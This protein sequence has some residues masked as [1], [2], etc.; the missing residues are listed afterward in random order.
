M[1]KKQKI[2][3]FLWV[4]SY[5]WRY[6]VRFIFGLLTGFFTAISIFFVLLQM[7]AVFEPLQ[8]EKVSARN[9]TVVRENK[10]LDLSINY[11]ND[12]KDGLNPNDK[13]LSVKTPSLEDLDKKKLLGK[14]PASV[15]NWL[16]NNWNISLE[17]E[18]QV[19]KV[20]MLIT[21]FFL[22]LAVLFK[23]LFSYI[24]SYLL[25]WLSL[26]FADD[27]RKEMIA[28]ILKKPMSFYH[29]NSVGEL[30]SRS[31]NDVNNMSR[32]IPHLL[33]AFTRTPIEFFAIFSFLVYK[34]LTSSNIDQAILF[35]LLI[36]PFTLIPAFFL[37]RYIKKYISRSLK[38]VASLTSTKQELFSCIKLI[39][40]SSMEEKEAKNFA[41]ESL[42]FFRDKKK[43]AR[44]SLAM[45]PF[46]ELFA[47]MIMAIFL[48]YC[49]AQDVSISSVLVICLSIQFAYEP[50]KKIS[51]LHAQI[52]TLRESSKRV[53]E[54]LE[55]TP[56]KTRK[57]QQSHLEKKSFDSEIEFKDVSFQY[58]KEE[59]GVLKN[60]NLKIKKGQFI[61]FVG[62]VGSGKTTMINLLARFYHCTKG[63]ILIDGIKIDDISLE[64]YYSNFSFVTQVNI[65]FNQSLRGNLTY[66]I[67]DFDEK[68][69]SEISKICGV[70][71]IA[72]HKNN[73]YD[74]VVGASGQL[75]SGGQRQRVS[76][77]RA[78]LK[79]A[80]ILVLDEATS[81]L[82]NI[83]EKRLQ[84]AIDLLSKEKTIIAVAHRLTTVRNADIIYVMDKGEIVEQGTH[85]QLVAQ[86]GLYQSMWHQ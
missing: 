41:Q 7:E 71:R 50:I 45:R 20:L 81:S 3:T 83:T 34:S 72:S 59:E 32:T 57:S 9:L 70:N 31:N 19:S 82:D 25:E 2:S 15:R 51:Q 58:H 85:S 65:L 5:L 30:I 11:P 77:A 43:I 69:L 67:D 48:Y 17:T 53:R 84:S 16:E 78:L 36:A 40:T 47:I 76:I 52:L 4:S 18:S 49:Y 64:S 75:L 28:K 79:N 10:V 38:K 8:G 14:I 62:S 56:E 42:N 6:K 1:K 68:Y 22:M 73:G 27:V 54:Y 39:K 44:F 26:K 23:S 63:E 12:A 80:S 29:K 35:L 86:S 66:G 74:F 61:A 60:I 33:T 24:N 37:G 21:I 13:I 55:D 46:T